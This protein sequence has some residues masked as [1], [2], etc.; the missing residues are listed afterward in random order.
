M[1]WREQQKNKGET[2]TIT[3]ASMKIN[4][5]AKSTKEHRIK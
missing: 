3:Y 5:E 1:E 4:N 2:L